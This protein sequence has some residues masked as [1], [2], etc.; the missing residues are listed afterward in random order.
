MPNVIVDTGI[1]AEV[2]LLFRWKMESGFWLLVRYWWGGVL[3]PSGHTMLVG[4]DAS[5]ERGM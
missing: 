2:C 1:V 3:A 4:M 5:F